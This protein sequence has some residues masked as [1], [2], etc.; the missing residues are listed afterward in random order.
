[1]NLDQEL[2]HERSIAVQRDRRG[3]IQLVVRGYESEAASH[4][5]G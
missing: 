4:S 3:A 5:Q 2:R 1:M